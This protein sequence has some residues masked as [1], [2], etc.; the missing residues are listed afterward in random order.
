L[1]ARL[2]EHELSS[3]RSSAFVSTVVKSPDETW[4]KFKRLCMWTTREYYIS[5]LGSSTTL[6]R[7]SS[8]VSSLIAV[9]GNMEFPPDGSFLK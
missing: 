4:D 7:L 1:W 8:P 9:H 5:G 2:C 6:L 3:V